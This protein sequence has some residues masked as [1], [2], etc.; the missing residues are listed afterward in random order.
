M[1][2]IITAHDLAIELGTTV[3]RVLQIA[4]NEIDR[5]VAEDG[6]DAARGLSTRIVS[7]RVALS[8]A[9]ADLVREVGS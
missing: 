3:A 5:V 8:P 1:A 7:G 6:L 9:L 2:N 4:D